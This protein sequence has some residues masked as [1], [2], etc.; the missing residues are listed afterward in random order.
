M[1][2]FVKFNDSNEPTCLVSGPAIQNGMKE[3]TKEEYERYEREIEERN[4][5]IEDAIGQS[6]EEFRK[7]RK[8]Q[9]AAFDI[10]KTNL[11]YGTIQESLTEHEA[12]LEWYN[13]MLEFPETINEKNYN[14]LV[15][16]ETPDAIKQYI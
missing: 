8:E 13:T 3:I 9:F 4:F 2:Y 6:S 14:S 1:R 12:I 11:A 16:P 10:Y 15:Y 7:F 5:S